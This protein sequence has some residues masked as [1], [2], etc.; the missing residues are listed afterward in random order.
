MA[1]S[2]LAPYATET[3]AQWRMNRGR[4]RLRVVSK[5]LGHAWIS[6]TADVY[7]IWSLLSDSGPWT[8]PLP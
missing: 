6:I 5:L 2:M 3:L 8:V 4:A 7:A 1:T